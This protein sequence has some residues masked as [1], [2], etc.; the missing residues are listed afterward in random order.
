MQEALNLR[1]KSK[2][3]KHFVKLMQ[4][5]NNLFVLNEIHFFF[6][7]V[8]TYRNTAKFCKDSCVQQIDFREID[9]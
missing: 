9:F 6:L 5:G 4:M 7:I 2:G 8:T 3:N 1:W